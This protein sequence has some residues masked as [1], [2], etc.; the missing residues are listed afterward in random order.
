MQ[1]VVFIGG[2]GCG[3]STLINALLRKEVLNIC[4]LPQ[5]GFIKKIVSGN[6]EKCHLVSKDGRKELLDSEKYRKIGIYDTNDLGMDSSFKDIDYIEYESS[7]QA[8]NLT[9]DIVNPYMWESDFDVFKHLRWQSDAIVF[10]VNAVNPFSQDEQRL[11]K[12]FIS[13][14]MQNVFFCIN[15]MDSIQ[16]DALEQMKQYFKEQLR[17]YFTVNNVF[18]KALYENRVFFTSAYYSLN[19]RLGKSSRTPYGEIEVK[20]I[21]T[22]VPE[23]EYTLRKFLQQQ[24]VKRLTYMEQQKTERRETSDKMMYD[25]ISDEKRSDTAG[26]DNNEQQM[27]LMKELIGMMSGKVS[28]EKSRDTAG[29]DDNE[30]QV[31][32][33]KK[34]IGMMSE[35][36]SDEKSSDTAGADNNE[37]QMQL[38]K[39]LIGMMSDKV[40]NEK[41]SE[42]PDR[43]HDQKHKLIV[44]CV[45]ETSCNE[46]NMSVEGEQ[47]TEEEIFDGQEFAVF[48]DGK[49]IGYC[50]AI[51]I[52]DSELL[53]N[54]FTGEINDDTDI[55]FLISTPI[56]EEQYDDALIACEEYGCY[57]TTV[58]YSHEAPNDNLDRSDEYFFYVTKVTDDEIHGRSLVG[59][60]GDDHMEQYVYHD[61]VRQKLN[62]KRH[63]ATG[64]NAIFE[65]DT[66]N[67]HVGDIITDCLLPNGYTFKC[68]QVSLR[69]YLLI[70]AVVKEKVESDS[71]LSVGEIAA[72]I[73]VQY[74]DQHPEIKNRK[75]TRMDE[76]PYRVILIEKNL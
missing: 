57:S 37:Q 49:I 65:A 46:A 31:Q 20:D 3:K 47:W 44:F 60:I 35:K 36:V 1:R 29:S 32:L 63:H 54:E 76:D 12:G 28:D 4:A 14:G 5:T 62:W 40:S 69:R 74:F 8:D 45:D 16:N 66:S 25:K 17:E 23:F 24:K 19:A 15:Q 51:C 48:D 39:E 2:Y 75:D 61:G 43:S 56:T 70:F 18:D 58:R 55:D 50:K 59:E 10:V 73:I 33:M 38:M 21:D 6:S 68:E 9:F 30:Q 72:Q 64:H 42:L 22:G 26:A 67:V 34:L 52:S 7:A 13:E 41:S 53:L 27:Q 71:S 11:I